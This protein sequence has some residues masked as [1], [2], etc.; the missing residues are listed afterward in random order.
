MLS[1]SIV[2]LIFDERQNDCHG[3]CDYKFS[4][5][6]KTIDRLKNISYEKFFTDY[7]IKNVPCII[8]LEKVKTWQ[9]NIDWKV[10]EKPNFDFLEEMFGNFFFDIL[11]VPASTY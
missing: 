5:S 3:I 11:K 8:S 9:S 10:D 1:K 2:T 4:S 6:N 7:L